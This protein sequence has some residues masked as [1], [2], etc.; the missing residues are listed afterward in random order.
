MKRLL[1]VTPLVVFLLVCH[2]VGTSASCSANSEEATW[3]STA[4]FHCPGINISCSLESNQVVCKIN[5]TYPVDCYCSEYYICD[6]MKTPETRNSHLSGN[7]CGCT[8]NGIPVISTSL[9]QTC[10]EIPMVHD[11]F[12]V[13]L[14]IAVV[15]LLV[16][17]I[18]IVLVVVCGKMRKNRGY[19][20]VSQE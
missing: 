7:M 1:F 6:G 15:L 19:T 4:N 18:G 20:L 13:P 12:S 17:T 8:Y 2:L 14:I 11:S 10:T 16:G 5:N 9:N 3:N